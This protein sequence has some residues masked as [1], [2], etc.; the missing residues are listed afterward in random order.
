MTDEK[1]VQ[2]RTLGANFLTYL[3]F[4]PTRF[5]SQS[6][7]DWISLRA[8]KLRVEEFLNDLLALVNRPLHVNCEPPQNNLK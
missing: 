7:S 8:A 5:S 4:I 1:C 2:L 3:I 6:L